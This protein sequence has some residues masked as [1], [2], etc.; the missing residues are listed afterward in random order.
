MT[1]ETT[2]QDWTIK[3]AEGESILGSAHLCASGEPRACVL[4]AHGFKGYKDYGFIPL[5]ASTLAGTEPV[6][7]HRFNFSHSGMNED[8]T[9]FGRP[10]LFEQDTWGKQVADLNAC[11]EAAAKGELPG[12]PAG[13]PIVLMGHSRGGV[14]CLLTASDR[15]IEG[16]D[17]TPACV[18]T[19]ASPSRAN[20]LS[21][22]DRDSLREQGYLETVSSRTGQTLRIGKAWLQ[23]QLDNPY[24]FD[25]LAACTAIA[26]P[27]LAVHGEQDQTV[28]A[29]GSTEI[30]ETA[31]EGEAFLIIDGDH[32]FNTPNPADPEAPH[33]HALTE[34][35]RVVS[36]F[37]ATNATR[38]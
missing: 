8:A 11:I 6:V 1:A 12:T 23:E 17:H 7:A 37:I 9:T 4:I 36:S 31:P 27:V 5:L 29:G 16:K 25:V 18:I 2:S 32:V 13:L 33:S 3:G 14:T 34:L 10:D 28:L 38:S 21:E 20:S 24:E 35:I 22:E 30:A 15:F 26:C 19:M